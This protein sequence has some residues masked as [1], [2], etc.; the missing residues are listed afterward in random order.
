ME[1]ITVDVGVYTALQIDLS[2][3]DFTDIEEVIFTIKNK[4]VPEETIIVE[5][6]FNSSGVYDIVIS[7]E[8]S[9]LLT[10]GAMYDFNAVYIDGNR[11][12]ISENGRIILRPCVGCCLDDEEQ[13]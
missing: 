4:P 10:D 2:E 8:E 13:S 7:P 1:F 11:F 3:F 5:R 6:T 12:K 9:V